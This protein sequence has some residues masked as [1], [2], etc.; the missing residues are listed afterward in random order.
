MPSLEITTD[1]KRGV[2]G[3]SAGAINC[4]ATVVLGGGDDGLTL[5]GLYVFAER[6]ALDR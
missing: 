1:P 3:I 5:L 4:C 6:D 2:H